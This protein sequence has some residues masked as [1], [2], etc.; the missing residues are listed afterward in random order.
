MTTWEKGIRATSGAI[1]PKKTYVYLMDFAWKG[2]AWEYLSC[3]KS[4]ASFAVYDISR[5]LRPVKRYEVWEA[6]ETLG[7][8]LAPDGNTM[9]QFDKLYNKVIKWADA[10]RTGRIPRQDVWL[11]YNSTTWRTLCYSLPAINLTWQQCDKLMTPLLTYVLPALGICRNFPRSMVF[12]P[13]QY[14]GIGI[15]HLYT[16][17][18]INR[19]KDILFHSRQ[20]TLLG[21]LYRNSISCLILELGLNLPLHSI[22]Y[23][24][25]QHLVTPSL[26]KSTWEFIFHHQIE[27]RHYLQ[28]QENR[29][30]DTPLMELFLAMA[31]SKEHLTSLNR[32]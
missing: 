15:K 13:V 24:M 27:L 10:M 19:L 32:C 16:V 30:H 25:M 31:P 4:P 29:Q 17:Q 14:M 8:Y 11:A 21:S 5:T 1:V 6:Q 23:T 22:S 3:D 2:G 28:C 12:A 9:A 18:E 20:N 7:V 26:I